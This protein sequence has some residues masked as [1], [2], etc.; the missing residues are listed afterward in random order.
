M[1]ARSITGQNGHAPAT[2]ERYLLFA[3]TQRPTDGGLGELL[4]TFTS[5]EEA[6]RA[7]RDVRLRMSSPTSWAQLAAVH[8]R[9]GLKP[10]CWFGIGAEPERVRP[11]PGRP[12]VKAGA[13]RA[14]PASDLRVVK[15]SESRATTA[16]PARPHPVTLASWLRAFAGRHRRQ[17]AGRRP[18]AR[19]SA[20]NR[21]P[22]RSL[23]E[24]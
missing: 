6:R 4:D 22:I 23:E 15:A 8:D 20:S 13:H 14:T 1:T 12:S 3:G 24:R 9:H 16:P 21:S 19:S 18:A 2:A 11:A 10:M 17:S 7:F 5:E